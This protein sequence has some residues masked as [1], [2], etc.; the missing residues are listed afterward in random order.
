MR[1]LMATK[2]GDNSSDNFLPPELETLVKCQIESG[3]FENAID[4]I[5]AGMNL[6]G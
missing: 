5:S 2:I 4:A 6:L 3:K 1:N